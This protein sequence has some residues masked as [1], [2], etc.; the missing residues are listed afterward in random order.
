MIIIKELKKSLLLH[1]IA[2]I[3]SIMMIGLWTLHVDSFP[4]WFNVG[5]ILVNLDTLKGLMC[6][7][8]LISKA[9]KNNSI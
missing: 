6:N 7:M 2:L 5:F 4:T 3:L 9:I 1:S 8:E